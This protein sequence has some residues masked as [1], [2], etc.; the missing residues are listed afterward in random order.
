[1]GN[2]RLP[3]SSEIPVNPETAH[4]LFADI[5]G[6]SRLAS[7]GQ[8]ALLQQLRHAVHNAADFNRARDAGTLL[9]LPTGDGMALVFFGNDV[10]AP[11]RTA[12]EISAA[13]RANGGV[14]LRIGI[15]TGPVFR[16]PDINGSET[17]KPVRCG[18]RS[19][20]RR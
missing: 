16:V 6:Y 8:P 3:A 11:I 5:V 17:E 15:H 20:A 14:G 9:C 10:C 7:D 18:C 13:L 1:M 4:V 19:A 2:D 12:T